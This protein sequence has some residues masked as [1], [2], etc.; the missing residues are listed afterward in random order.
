MVSSD[1][2]LIGLN[3]LAEQSMNWTRENL[4]QDD[5]NY[6][7]NLKLVRQVR[8]FTIAHATLDSPG[9][10]GYITSKF[11]ALES[12]GYQ[13]TPVCFIGHTHVPAFYVKTSSVEELSG[14]ILDVESSKKYLINVGSVGQP[15]DGD[16]RASYCIYDLGGQRIVN[17][18]VEYDIKS[19]QEKIIDAGL[20]DKLAD[21]LS[22][23]Q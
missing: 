11:H 19:A 5:K 16:P 4:S 3:P 12:F 7:M 1:A 18:R 17:R 22:H 20:P 21:R 8:D 23:G 10:W 14:R 15:R 6:L 13:Y 2:E 9:G